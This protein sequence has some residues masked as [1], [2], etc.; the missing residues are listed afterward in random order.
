M[1]VERIGSVLSVKEQAVLLSL[2]RSSLYYTPPPL[3]PQEVA[4]KH[5]I[6]A[7]YTAYPF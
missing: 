3:S 1:K 7:I 4:V 2:S 5:R 6:D